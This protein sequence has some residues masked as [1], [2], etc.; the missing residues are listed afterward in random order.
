MGPLRRA[1]NPLVLLNS[2]NFLPF[3]DKGPVRRHPFPTPPIATP[4]PGARPNFYIVETVCVDLYVY[5]YVYID[6]RLRY[7]CGHSCDSCVRARK[8]AHVRVMC[9]RMPA[10]ERRAGGGVRGGRRTQG[11]GE[12]L[13]EI[14]NIQKFGIGD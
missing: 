2:T 1:T 7:L 6:F 13:A 11:L 8:R 14:F 4:S 12:L 10:T 5:V 3:F 9:T